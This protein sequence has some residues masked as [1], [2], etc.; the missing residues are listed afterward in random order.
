MT[1]SHLGLMLLFAF[2]VSLVFAVIA[3]DHPAGQL[4]LGS[5]FF[6]GFVATGLI[7]GWVM[8][9]LPL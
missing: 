1:T 9:A 6:G 2:F 7:L 4:K 3:E 5:K 8:L